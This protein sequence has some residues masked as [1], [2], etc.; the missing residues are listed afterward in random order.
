MSPDETDLGTEML[1]VSA[2]QKSFGAGAETG[3]SNRGQCPLI[4]EL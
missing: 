2:I 3:A 4:R 1:R